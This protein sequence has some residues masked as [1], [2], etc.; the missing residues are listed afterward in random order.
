M[1]TNGHGIPLVALD[2]DGT[3]ADYHT[4]FLQF[5]ERWIGKPMPH[6]KDINPGKRLSEWMGVEHSVYQ[7]CKLAFRQ[8]GL[9]RW[10]PAYDGASNLTSSIAH[11]GAEVWIC[12][13]R[14]YLRLD[15]IDP[16]T[17]EW[18]A[19]NGIHYDAVLFGEH[20]YAE[21]ARQAGDRVVAVF[22]DLP[23]QCDQAVGQGFNT[24]V[25]D[26]PYNRHY[27]PYEVPAD[28][29]GRVYSCFDMLEICRKWIRNWKEDHVNEG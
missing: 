27:T 10:M 18:L 15:N 20:K 8:G 26:Q 23:E 16:D 7:E 25:R 5:A 1:R 22:D 14:P 6:P 12:T 2:I 24:W 11:M 19:R 9:K 29:R 17:R 4:H 28:L 13:T 21:L 3:L